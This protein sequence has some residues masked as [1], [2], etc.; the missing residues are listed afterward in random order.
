MIIHNFNKTQDGLL[1]LLMTNQLFLMFFHGQPKNVWYLSL[2]CSLVAWKSFKSSRV[3]IFN[4]FSINKVD[5]YMHTQAWK[6]F[7]CELSKISQALRLHKRE[8]WHIFGLPMFFF[9]INT[10]FKNI[11]IIKYKWLSNNS[12][13]QLRLFNWN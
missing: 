8:I 12:N 6:I 7:T 9:A 2:L 4:N 3:E 13:Y 5:L 10:I 11:S 1:W